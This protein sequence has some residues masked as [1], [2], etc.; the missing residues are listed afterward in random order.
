MV[1]LKTI[2]EIILIKKSAF[3]A[4]KTLGMLAKEVKPGIHTLY[5]DKLAESFICDHG[6]K[7]AF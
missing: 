1:Q 5:L 4:S 2:A 3:L 7:P 6:G